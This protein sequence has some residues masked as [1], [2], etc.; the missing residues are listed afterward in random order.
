MWFGLELQKVTPDA[1]AATGL[2]ERAVAGAQSLWPLVVVLTALAWPAT[3]LPGE[4]DE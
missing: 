1:G 4:S 2:A 3:T